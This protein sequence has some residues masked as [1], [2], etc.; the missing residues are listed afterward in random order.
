MWF[1]AWNFSWYRLSL[2]LK[3]LYFNRLIVCLRLGIIALIDSIFSSLKRY[4]SSCSDLLIM[5]QL[6]YLMVKPLTP[7]NIENAILIVQRPPS[8]EIPF[9]WVFQLRNR[10][11]ICHLLSCNAPDMWCLSTTSF[12]LPQQS[13]CTKLWHMVYWWVDHLAVAPGD[14]IL[15]GWSLNL[16]LYVQT[17]SVLAEIKRVAKSKWLELCGKLTREDNGQRK[18]IFFTRSVRWIL[19]GNKI[20]DANLVFSFGKSDF[21]VTN[22]ML[23]LVLHQKMTVEH[24]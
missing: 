7:I 24:G 6:L 14:S 3:Y 18:M 8:N 10:S 13:R 4:S 16:T 12:G 20:H 2:S 15:M 23:Q 21:H 19:P 11:L 17:V 22:T 9:S 1:E 5:V